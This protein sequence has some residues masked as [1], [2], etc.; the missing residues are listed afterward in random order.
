V[1]LLIPC[2]KCLQAYGEAGVKFARVSVR[3]DGKYELT[4][5]HGHR[6]TTVLQQQKFEVLFDI[7]AHAVLDG[8]YREAISCF[9]ASLERFY[10]FS[11]RALLS[12]T[13]GSD[14]LFKTCWKSVS[15]QS[16]RQ[17]GAFIFLW[18]SI[19]DAPP[20][21]LSIKH[22]GFRNDVI[23]KGKIPT[24]EEAI[25][26]GDSILNVLR[27]NIVALCAQLPDSVKQVVFYHLRDAQESGAT[28][29]YA[30]LC[31]S[32]IVS[33]SNRDAS[34]H[35]GNLKHHLGKLLERRAIENSIKA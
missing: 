35:E 24:M 31:L 5:S 2:M 29:P 3:D 8:Y 22:V 33:L 11:I 25:V 17:L 15:S 7:G 12:R 16:E 34:H 23:H 30:T 1:R 13:S 9:A 27:P 19:F 26:F 18:A 4:C 20:A 14:G 6:A 28:Y 10:E 21:L 32:T